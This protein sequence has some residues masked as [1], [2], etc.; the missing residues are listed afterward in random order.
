MYKDFYQL[1]TDPFSTHPDPDTIFIS[2]THK[3]AWHYLL[4]SMDN[5]EPYLSR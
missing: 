1:K 4:S 5:Q 3:E 2:N